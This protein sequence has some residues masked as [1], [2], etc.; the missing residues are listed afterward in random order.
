MCV[1][2][3]GLRRERRV[4]T[5]CNCNSR[6]TLKVYQSQQSR[7][8]GRITKCQRT[9]EKHFSIFVIFIR[10]ASNDVDD[11]ESA[12]QWETSWGSTESSSGHDATQQPVTRLHWGET[13]PSL[14]SG[15]SNWFLYRAVYACI[16]SF[17]DLVSLLS[18]IWLLCLLFKINTM[19]NIV[20]G[21]SMPAKNYTGLNMIG[22]WSDKRITLIVC[23]HTSNIKHQTATDHNII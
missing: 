7:M 23:W 8:I 21:T 5:L 13:S 6:I 20:C 22:D 1:R 18:D 10:L 14:S 17:T 16:E 15:F 3:W 19:I 12:M 9:S 11:G 2:V 4:R